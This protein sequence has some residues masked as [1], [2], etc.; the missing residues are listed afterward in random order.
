MQ[1][2]SN[3]HNIIS[4]EEEKR[5]LQENIDQFDGEYVA[6]IFKFYRRQQNPYVSHTLP[7]KLVSGKTLYNKHKEAFDKFAEIAIKNNFDVDRY[8]KYCVKCGINE[9]LVETCLSST[10]MID[11]YLDYVNR[12]E[13]ILIDQYTQNHK[14]R[15]EHY[16]YIR[17][18]IY[19]DKAAFLM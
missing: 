8:I 17:A 1:N 2:Q 6:K 10:T 7:V 13:K 18:R 16:L 14:L 19:L 5:K 3:F 12:F 11:K 4:Q 15:A 9:N